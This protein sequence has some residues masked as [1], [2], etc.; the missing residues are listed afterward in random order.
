MAYRTSSVS[1]GTLKSRLLKRPSRKP[2]RGK[3]PVI[4]IWSTGT[5]RFSSSCQSRTTVIDVSLDS[6]GRGISDVPR[7]YGSAN[8][9]NSGRAAPPPP[10]TA[11]AMYC[12]P[13]DRVTRRHRRERH[14]SEI[15]AVVLMVSVDRARCSR[16]VGNMPPA[17]VDEQ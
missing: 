12:L 17:G 8:A 13:C 10:P 4:H 16:F 15:L 14:R 7:P 2:V 5:S 9:I 11:T 6:S 1:L 3:R